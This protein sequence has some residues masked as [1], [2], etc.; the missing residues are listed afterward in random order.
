[1]LRGSALKGRFA[2]QQM[3]AFAQSSRP[4]SSFRPQISRFPVRQSKILSGNATWVPVGSVP[5][6]RFNSTSSS[7]PT[8]PDVS[9]QPQESSEWDIA[10]LDINSIP[11]KIG[12][13]KDVGLD[14][15]WGPSA[16]NEFIFEHIHMWTGLSWLGS[17]VATG[18]LI[19][20]AI[21]PIFF[22]SA[23][24]STKM[25]NLKH[26]LTPLRNQRLA[27]AQNGNNIE[28]A[29]AKAKMTEVYKKHDITPIKAF[30]PMFIQAP[31]GYGSFR[32]ITGMASLPIPGLAAEKFL[33]VSDLT[34]ADP[35]FV[36]PA[37]TAALVHFSI[38]RGGE[39]G[40]MDDATRAIRNG[41]MYGMPALSF[42]FMVFQPGA[43]QI[44][45]A[46]TAFVGLVQAH[47]IASKP[48]RRLL[49]ITMPDPNPPGAPGGTTID[50]SRTLRMLEE[51]IDIERAKLNQS[52]QAP[53]SQDQPQQIS[54]IDRAINS[55]KESKNKALQELAAKAK[56][57][58]GRVPKKNP[59]GTDAE[60]PRLSEKDLKLAGDYEKRRKEEEA[61]KREERNHARREAY[62]RIMEEQREKARGA[63]KNKIKQ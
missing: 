45:F 26:I 14:Y 19:R 25:S 27:A 30:L 46:V 51:R 63:I 10:N 59:D 50:T 35:L 44:Y 49:G 3:A 48:I 34:V 28:A 61:W 53:Q 18:L 11:E 1:M 39:M 37:L 17:I 52:S 33:W 41:L 22:R 60:P 5:G 6:A 47:M 21:M 12:Y 9:P 15:G 4:M 32:V 31:L 7:S 40:N 56:E 43:L 23:D 57:A 54:F 16:L 55:F 29:M 13:L 42:A 58:S 62:M 2:R 38:K 8:T 20:V 36:L 24:T